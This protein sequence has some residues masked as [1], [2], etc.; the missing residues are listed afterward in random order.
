MYINMDDFWIHYEKKK[1]SYLGKIPS[2]D[3]WDEAYQ[4][5]LEFAS[6]EELEADILK[7]DT[8]EKISKVLGF[9]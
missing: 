6:P 2:E 9:D 3:F 8:L 7:R 5:F 4:L 1:S